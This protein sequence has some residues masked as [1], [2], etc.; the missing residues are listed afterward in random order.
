M[1]VIWKSNRWLIR[2]EPE[3]FLIGRTSFKQTAHS[4]S[5]QRRW[6]DYNQELFGRERVVLRV[7]HETGWVELPE[8]SVLFGSPPHDRGTWN[9]S[10]LRRLSAE[11]R[12]VERLTKVGMRNLRILFRL[13]HRTGCIFEMVIDATLKHAGGL[14]SDIIDHVIRQVV[15]ECRKFQVKFPNAAIIVSMRNEWSAHNLTR[16]RIEQ[17]NKWAERFFRWKKGQE[18]KVSRTSPG[19][20]W[21]AEQWPEGFCIVDD[22]GNNTLTY[23]A[24]T[25]AGVYQMAALHPLRRREWW[26]GLNKQE[27]R[28]LERA[29]HSAPLGF[30]ESMYYVDRD[31]RVRARKWYNGTDGWAW[32]LKHY[33]E[34]LNTAE[35]QVQYMIVHDEKGVQADPDWPRKITRLER[36]LAERYG[37]RVGG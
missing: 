25:K 27:L 20:G 23:K 5:D 10:E 11:G 31:D 21:T 32:N 29:A 37:G 35:K 9:I 4:Q 30:T 13:S 26:K 7:F 34:F 6:V 16:T 18:F 33:V 17:V 19:P 22:G 2:G 1:N 3:T 14:T 36:H 15:H 12:R 24:G 8:G 28:A